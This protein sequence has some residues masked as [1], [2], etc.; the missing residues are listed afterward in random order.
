LVKLEDED[1]NKQGSSEDFLVDDQGFDEETFAEMVESS[2]SGMKDGE[3]VTG[4]VV[5]VTPV[6]VVMDIGYKAEGEIPIDEFLDIPGGAESIKPGD[7]FEV[8]IE[9]RFRDGE[10]EQVVLSRKRAGEVSAWEKIEKA[11]REDGK[12]KG[13]IASRVKGGLRV[14]VGV[15][16][17]LPGSQVDLRPVRDLESIIGQEFDFKVLKYSRRR[18]NV[19]LS[20]RVILEQER[21]HLRDKLLATLKDGQ[22]LDGVVK[23]VVKYGAFIDLGGMDG[24]LHVSDMSWGRIQHPGDLVRVGQELKVKVLKFDRERGRISLGLKQLSPDPWE[25]AGENC[26]VGAMVK[27]RVVNVVDYGAFVEIAPGL[28]GLIHV[29][30]MSWGN[31]VRQAGQ[32]LTEGQE[33][34]AVVLSLDQESRKLALSLKR[35]EPDP[36]DKLAEKFPVGTVI[37]GLIKTATEFGLFIGLEEGIDGMIHRRDVSWSN[38]PPPPDQEFE[39]GQTVRA[40]VLSVDPEKKKIALGMK[41]LTP[42]PWPELTAHLTPGAELSGTVA[43]S[44]EGGLAIDLGEGI[45]G[46]VPLGDQELQDQAAPEKGT[47]VQVRVVQADPEKRQ[48]IL[49]LSGSGEE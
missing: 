24:L 19:V 13:T 39:P 18:R 31:D 14:D 8:L 45:Q 44:S 3:V 49:A 23:N 4:R 1:R 42:D 47:E 32:V 43:G 34:E 30:E 40:M 7:T 6:G 37:E 9:S 21:E 10:E 2:L 28:E 20:R 36:W 22:V 35:I 15:P 26:P 46:L 5:E 27:G 11:Y 16:A 33:V 48:V 41:Q 25:T 29:S 17:F 38:D 12:I